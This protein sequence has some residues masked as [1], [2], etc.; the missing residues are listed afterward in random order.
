MSHLEGE[1]M[2]WSLKMKRNIYAIEAQG[3]LI[4]CVSEIW[5]SFSFTKMKKDHPMKHN[6]YW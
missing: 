5:L 3:L 4:I 6:Q 2:K 1:N